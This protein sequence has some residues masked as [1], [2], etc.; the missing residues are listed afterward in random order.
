M[1]LKYERQIPITV[2]KKMMP[3]IL[4]KVDAESREV[5]DA[6]NNLY[7]TM[8]TSAVFK[9]DSKALKQTLLN[10]V[11]DH[12]SLFDSTIDPTTLSEDTREYRQQLFFNII[13]QYNIK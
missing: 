1:L 10:L 7:V 13:K 5:M 11:K 4:D 2:T 9:E 3:E 8:T 6:I 12:V